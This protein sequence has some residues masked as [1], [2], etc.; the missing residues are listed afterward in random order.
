MN[1]TRELYGSIDRRF[2]PSGLQV[3]IKVP[4]K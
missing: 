3:E 1:I 4:L 2:L